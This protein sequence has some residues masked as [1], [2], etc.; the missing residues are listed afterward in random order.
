MFTVNKNPSTKELQKFG[1]AMLIGFS[2]IAF[3]LYYGRF[4]RTWNEIALEYTATT[5][6]LTACCVQAFGVGLLLLSYAWPAGA[7]PVYIVWMTV[8]I[9]IGTVMTTAML[10]LLFLLLLPVFSLIVRL[11]DPLRKKL[12]N[13]GTYW[14]DYKKHEAT[15][16]RAG[17]PF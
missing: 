13:S 7:K 16:E 15:L 10:T 5:A 6:Q 8:G 11:G 9:K 3:L 14:E 17:R 2:A 1:L 12:N 4:L